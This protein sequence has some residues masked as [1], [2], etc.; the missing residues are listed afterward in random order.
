MRQAHLQSPNRALI[1][2]L[3]WYG[4][5]DALALCAFRSL[6]YI[7]TS[8]TRPCLHSPASVVLLVLARWCAAHKHNEVY[9]PPRTPYIL[10]VHARRYPFQYIYSRSMGSGPRGA[11]HCH[12]RPRDGFCTTRCRPPASLAH[13]HDIAMDVKAARTALAVRRIVTTRDPT[14]EKGS[15]VALPASLPLP[16]PLPH[17]G[18][19]AKLAVR[20]QFTPHSHTRAFQ[21][22]GPMRQWVDYFLKKVWRVPL[23]TRVSLQTIGLS[24]SDPVYPVWGVVH[25]LPTL[26]LALWDACLVSCGGPAVRSELHHRLN[27]TLTMNDIQRRNGFAWEALYEPGPVP[28]R[29]IQS[30][31]LPLSPKAW[32]LTWLLGPVFLM[33]CHPF[34]GKDSDFGAGICSRD[35]RDW[36]KRLKVASAS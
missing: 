23:Q 14:K 4:W 31:N 35:S 7:K 28:S 19:P 16:L 27:P 26:K 36:K 15:S 6:L 18:W 1:R 32:Q 2:P 22:D 13:S 11:C 5:H 21:K 33:E 3:G 12:G 20:L 29:P 25:W 30:L 9:M 17:S 10:A 34:T 8:S 24:I